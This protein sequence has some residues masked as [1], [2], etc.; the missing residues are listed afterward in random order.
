MKSQKSKKE[1]FPVFIKHETPKSGD[2]ARTTRTYSCLRG[3]MARGTLV[4]IIGI[5]SMRGYSI[6][7]QEGNCILE[8]GWSI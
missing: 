2:W 1:K 7:D 6:Q 5:D 4:K 3:T 8:I